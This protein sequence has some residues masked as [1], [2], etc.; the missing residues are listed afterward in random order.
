MLFLKAEIET[1]RAAGKATVDIGEALP[2]IPATVFAKWAAE[3]LRTNRVVQNFFV[4][5]NHG[6]LLSNNR[7]VVVSPGIDIR[8][9]MQD[10][11]AVGVTQGRSSPGNEGVTP[12]RSSMRI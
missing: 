6:M 8:G 11:G 4:D 12:E 10:A 5:E 2:K 9:T 1:R 3:Y 7:S